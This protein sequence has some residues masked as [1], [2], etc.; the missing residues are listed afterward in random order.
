[1]A[2]HGLRDSEVTW[3][4]FVD[5]SALF[6]LLSKK[7]DLTKWFDKLLNEPYILCVTDAVKQEIE[8][9]A[10]VETGK[11]R[12]L[13]KLATTFLR[14]FRVV[15]TD[16]RVADDSIVEASIK[17]SNSLAFTDDK[18]LRQR[19]KSLGVGVFLLTRDGRVTLSN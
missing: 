2:P 8:D 17:T 15:G 13:A 14:D 7:I 4:I 11:I 1:M 9:I 19:L 16:T 18:L 5:T 3:M 10:I 12:L 6:H